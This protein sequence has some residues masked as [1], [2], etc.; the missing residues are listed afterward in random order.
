MAYV[1]VLWQ[2]AVKN[3]GAWGVSP[4]S[5]QNAKE[6]EVNYF[7]PVSHTIWLKVTTDISEV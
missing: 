2:T 4:F 6:C 5:L 7:K 3:I 1:S